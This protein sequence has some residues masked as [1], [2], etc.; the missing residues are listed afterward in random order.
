MNNIDKI[1]HLLTKV[2]HGLPEFGQV[3]IVKSI[4]DHYYS[5]IIYVKLEKGE[6]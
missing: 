1:L 4:S 3:T 2:D 5:A 6:E